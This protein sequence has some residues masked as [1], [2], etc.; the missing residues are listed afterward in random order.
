[1]LDNARCTMRWAY[2]A[3]RWDNAQLV[4]WWDNA[5]PIHSWYAQCWAYPQL[6]RQCWAYPQQVRQCWANPQLAKAAELNEHTGLIS[7]Q[8]WA[9]MAAFGHSIQ[10]CNEKLHSS[11]E[12]LH[13]SYEKL[14]LSYE[15]LR[16]SYKCVSAGIRAD[17][18]NYEKVI[19]TYIFYNRLIEKLIKGF[20]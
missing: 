6:V 7:R 13:S 16:L 15:K 19:S 3:G 9:K 18:E 11:Y 17:K 10:T 1:M 5:G 2:P 8:L 12:K 14:R 4:Q 20:A